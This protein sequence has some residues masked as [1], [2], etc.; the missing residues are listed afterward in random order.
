MSFRIEVNKR[1]LKLVFVINTPKAGSPY[2]F[3]VD[4]VEETRKGLKPTYYSRIGVGLEEYLADNPTAYHL[5]EGEFYL[6]D[7]DAPEVVNKLVE[8]GW[9][10]PVIEANPLKG[11]Y[12]N[13]WV[14]RLTDKAKVHT[15]KVTV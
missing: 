3:G 14:Y 8:E 9:V 11:G 5:Q 7:Y 13:F 1:K 4:L 12:V 15:L 10:E 2:P 6:R